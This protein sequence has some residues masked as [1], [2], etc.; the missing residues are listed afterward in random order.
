MRVTLAINDIYKLKSFFALI[1]AV[2]VKMKL[3]TCSRVA[4]SSLSIK[5]DFS[6]MGVAGDLWIQTLE[7]RYRLPISVL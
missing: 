7:E 2:F 5:R 1:F 3:K 4:E 6:V